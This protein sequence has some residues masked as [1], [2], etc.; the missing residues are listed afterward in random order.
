M[1]DQTGIKLLN[2][3]FREGEEVCV[4]HNKYGYA[5]VPLSNLLEDSVTLIAT[6]PEIPDTIVQT[7]DLL[8]VALN[9]IKGYR[10]DANCTGLRNFLVE[11]DIMMPKDQ[12]AY[13]KRLGMPYSA[14]IFSGNKSLHFLIS[15]DRDCANERSYKFMANYILNTVRAADQNT[16]NPSRSIRIP[17]ALREPGKKQILLPNEFHGPISK[18]TLTAWLSKRPDL[19]PKDQVKSIILSDSPNISLVPRWVYKALESGLDTSKGRNSAWFTVSCEFALAGFLK[20]DIIREIGRFFQEERDF[21][22]SEW[23]TIIDSAVKHIQR[24]RGPNG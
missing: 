3:M 5:S 23:L 24:N 2:L 22:E 11:L 21:R 14:V 20:D 12:L 1:M 13:V 16:K 8:M 9:P 4:S 6:N 19:K 10:R 17:G 18:E 15:I 7:K